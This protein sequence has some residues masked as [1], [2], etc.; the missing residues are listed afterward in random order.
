VYISLLT[1]TA[2]YLLDHTFAK[3]NDIYITSAALSMGMPE[4]HHPLLF[5]TVETCRQPMWDFGPC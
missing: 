4:C 2:H 5:L 3:F 1:L